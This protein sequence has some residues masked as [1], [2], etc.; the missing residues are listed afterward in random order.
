MIDAVYM[1]APHPLG[2]VEKYIHTQSRQ[3]GCRRAAAHRERESFCNWFRVL[4]RGGPISRRRFSMGVGGHT[5]SSSSSAGPLFLF[6]LFSSRTKQHGRLLALRESSS[7]T[8]CVGR[9]RE[10]AMNIIIII[11][12]RALVESVEPG[13]SLSLDWLTRNQLQWLPSGQPTIF[14]SLHLPQLLF[15]LGA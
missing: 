9:E 8:F 5:S 6:G 1:P 13:A 14:F 7:L 11:I 4:T 15:P 3:R 10:P 2:A 12:K